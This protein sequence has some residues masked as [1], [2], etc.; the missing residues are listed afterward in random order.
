[1]GRVL[2]LGKDIHFLLMA[3]YLERSSR[4]VLLRQNDHLDGHKHSRIALFLP[5]GSHLPA[6]FLESAE[7]ARSCI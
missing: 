2:V 1:M 7:V 4:P 3:L 6:H 5:T